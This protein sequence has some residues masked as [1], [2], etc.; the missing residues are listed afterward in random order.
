MSPGSKKVPNIVTGC[1]NGIKTTFMLDSAADMTVVNRNLIREDQLTGDKVTLQG[2]A[3]GMSLTFPVACVVIHSSDLS[4][5]MTVA[6]VDI[7]DDNDGG[8]IGTDV[9]LDVFQALM[10]QASLTKMHAKSGWSIRVTRAQQRKWD[11]EEKL[12]RRQEALDKATPKPMTDCEISELPEVDS[13]VDVTQNENANNFVNI[14]HEVGSTVGSTVAGEVEESE[15][16]LGIDSLGLE[17]LGLESIGHSREVEWMRNIDVEG[18]SDHDVGTPT[19]LEVVCKAADESADPVQRCL[20]ELE[21]PGQLVSIPFKESFTQETKSDSTLRKYRGWANKRENNFLWENGLLKKDTFGPDGQSCSVVVVPKKFREEIMRI[22]HDNFGHSSDKR[23][24]SIISSKTVWPF[25]M[26]DIK[27]WCKCCKICQRHSKT[28]PARAPMH[29]VP[30]LTEPFEQVAVDLVGPFPRSRSGHKYLLTMV[31]M[32]SRYPE[33]LPLKSITAEEVAEGMAELFCRHGIPRAILSDQGKQFESELFNQLCTKLKINKFR[34]SPYHPQ[35]NGIVERFHGTLIPMLRK[36]LKGGKDWP[37]QL[38]YCLFAIRSTPNRSTGFSPFQVLLARDARSPLDLVL[39]ELEQTNSE[40]V[41][42]CAWIKNLN[43]HLEIIR[44]YVRA[45]SLS[46]RDERK[47]QHDKGTKVR[48]FPPGMLV[49]LR[50]PGLSGKLDV[51]WEG[52]LE[53]ESVPCNAVNVKLKIPGR[54]GKSRVVHV[55][56]VKEYVQDSTVIHRLVV[57]AEEPS[58]DIEYNRLAGCNL[59]VQQLADIENIKNKWSHVLNDAPGNTNRA[60]H[61]IDT[62]E[63][64]PIRS[65]QPYLIS[66]HKLE[67]VKKE[68]ESLLKLGII[69]PSS[70]PWSSPFVPSVMPNSQLSLLNVSGVRNMYNIWVM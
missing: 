52:P 70:S 54:A 32:A 48:K 65:Q 41:D 58:A 62:G 1:V 19:S 55:N 14:H 25:M 67:G 57:Y 30:V 43:D 53:I 64:P 20:S 40:P 12:M 22:A 7:L 33:A 17:S 59:S 4:F 49:F 11:K 5:P 47:Y 63:T 24:K 15:Q 18:L 13:P 6:A 56:N 31:D 9:D 26:K 3:P 10:K 39:D 66:P 34:S 35:S 21:C 8:L 23:T 16:N 50:T 28:K 36:A 46:A 51:S 45:N 44:D 38:K 42:V 29:E 61:G 69:E 68:V 37:K 60:I 27:A 2:Y